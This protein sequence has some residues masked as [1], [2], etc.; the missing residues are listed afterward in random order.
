MLERKKNVNILW[1]IINRF[2]NRK[3]RKKSLI[4][5]ITCITLT[6]KCKK[7]KY[8]KRKKD[9][10]SQNLIETMEILTEADL[11]FYHEAKTKIE[12]YDEEWNKKA[13]DVG[14]RSTASKVVDQSTSDNQ[15]PPP[16]FPS[17]ND[18]RWFTHSVIAYLLCSFLRLM[19][20]WK[21]ARRRRRFFSLWFSSVPYE[22]SFWI[23][24]FWKTSKYL[25][26]H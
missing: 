17:L 3:K 26:I 21:L 8:K 14:T 19:T 12:I 13:L 4:H 25:N 10:S 7:K 1:I 15:A 16:T 22:F 9:K 18:I 24:L 20:T 11:M 6:S 23:F 2:L 5:F